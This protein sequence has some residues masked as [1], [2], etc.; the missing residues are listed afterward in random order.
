MVIAL[1]QYENIIPETLEVLYEQLDHSELL[2]EM[3][4]DINTLQKLCQYLEDMQEELYG[5][6]WE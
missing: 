3:D 2:D 4:I 1:K 6:R 5:D